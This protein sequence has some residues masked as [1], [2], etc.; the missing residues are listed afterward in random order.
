M[1][2]ELKEEQIVSAEESGETEKT[3]DESQL[4]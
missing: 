1:A 4:P 3:M 2:E